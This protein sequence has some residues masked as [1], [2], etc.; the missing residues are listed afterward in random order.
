M[1]N[2][3]NKNKKVIVTRVHDDELLENEMSIMGINQL[4][5]FDND[6]CSDIDKFPKV[7]NLIIG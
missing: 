7:V 3:N 6:W 4:L 2:K 5:I 1:R